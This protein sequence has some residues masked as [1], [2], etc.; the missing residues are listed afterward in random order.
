MLIGSMAAALPPV[1]FARG[2]MEYL[3]ISMKETNCSRK[4]NYPDVLSLMKTN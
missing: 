3:V 4:R 2:K 1:T